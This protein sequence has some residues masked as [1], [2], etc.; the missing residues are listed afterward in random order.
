MNNNKP[1]VIVLSLLL[2][3]GMLL[4]V[5]ASAQQR[6]LYGGLFGYNTWFTNAE[7]QEYGLFRYA[8]E[9]DGYYNLFN[10]QFGSDEQGGYE[11]YNQTFGQDYEEAPLGSGLLILVAAGAGYALKK[12]KSNNKTVS[13]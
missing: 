12:S 5:G 13:R 8:V 6:Y 1:K 2:I 4:P 11:L 7:E 10:Q 9:E 3:V